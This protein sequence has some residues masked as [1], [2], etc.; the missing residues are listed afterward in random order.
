VSDCPE[1]ND[2]GAMVNEEFFLPPFRGWGHHRCVALLY[3]WLI[4]EQS[5][6]SRIAAQRDRR[7]SE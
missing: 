1:R 3:V 6:E 5:Y 2:L 4:V 7:T